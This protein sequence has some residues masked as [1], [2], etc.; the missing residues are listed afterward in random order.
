VDILLTFYDLSGILCYCFKG[1][2]KPYLFVFAGRGSV[3][4]TPER[5]AGRAVFF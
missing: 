3:L 5:M 1:I 2:V 4:S